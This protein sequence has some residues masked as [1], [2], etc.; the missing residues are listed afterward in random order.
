VSIHSPPP[1]WFRAPSR[2][3]RIWIGVALTWCLVMSAMM[4][5]W[6]FKGRQNS[7]GESYAV[8][9]ADFD[10]RV[11]AFVDAHK[12]GEAENGF[13]VVE[14]PPGGE[15]YLKGQMWSWYPVLRLRRGQT[16]RLHVSSMDLQHGLSIQ[17]VNMNFQVLPGY[18]HVLTVTP[19]ETKDYQ[20]ICNEFCGIG[21]HLMVGRISV[22]E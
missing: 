7:T 15:A 12:V 1:D 6:H 13:P 9:P 2:G 8:T 21:H 17:P 18:D 3:E 5:F 14:P 20:V 19:T 16:Y 10:A 11:S 22:V 4:P